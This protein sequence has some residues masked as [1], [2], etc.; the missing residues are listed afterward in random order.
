[1]LNV[2]HRLA[3]P[4]AALQQQHISCSREQQLQGHRSGRGAGAATGAGG[5]EECEEQRMSWYTAV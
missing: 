5:Y 2:Y 4:S 1:M 3:V